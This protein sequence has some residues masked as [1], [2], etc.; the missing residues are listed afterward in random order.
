MPENP[1]HPLCGW[2][3]TKMENQFIQKSFLPKPLQWSLYLLTGAVIFKLF[4]QLYADYD[5]WWHIFMGKEIIT[6]ETLGKFDIYSFTAY[7]LPYINHEW[8]SEIIM[9]WAY[10]VGGS[11]GLLIWRWSMVL[12]ILFLAF[13]LI[14]LKAQHPVTRIIIILCFS[15][16]LSPGISFRVQLFSYLLLLALLFLIYSARIKDQLPSVFVVSILFVLWANS[17]WC[18]CSRAYYLACL[19]NRICLSTSR[20]CQLATHIVIHFAS[21]FSNFHQSFWHR[22]M[23]IY[24]P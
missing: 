4:N 11:G 22:S 20:Y 10:L 15:L 14:K 3:L 9:A 19:C 18:V 21:C 5:L 24:L 6:K 2:S 8:L 12:I 16:V 23:A 1:S 17:A 13:R 7:G